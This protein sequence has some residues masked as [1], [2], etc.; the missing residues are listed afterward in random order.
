M[1]KSLPLVKIQNTGGAQTNVPFT[2]GQVFAP[3]DLAPTDGLMGGTLALQVDVKAAH[4]DGS[5]RHAVIS[6]VLPKLAAGETVALQLAK[7]VPAKTG[8]VSPDVFSNLADLDAK[9]QLVVGADTYTAS[10][11]G[12]RFSDLKLWLSGST[13][14]EG[15]FRVPLK[16]AAGI[17]HP[18]LQVQ[19]GVRYY[20]GA[21]VAR[22]EVIVENSKTWKQGSNFTYDV[23]V[24]VAG[25][26]V[27]SKKAQPH[28]HHARW[29][30]VAW[31][32]G[33]PGVLV[34][35][36]T[37]Y[38]IAAKAVPNYDQTIVPAEST[39]ASLGAQVT[40]ANTG[41]MTIG[42]VMADMGSTGGRPDIGPLPQWSVYYLLSRDRRAYD[43]M[44]AAAEGSASWS[45]H[46]RDENT[47]YPLRTD[48]DATKNVSMHFNMRDQGPLPVPRIDPADKTGGGTPYANDTAHEPSLVYLPYLITG[49]YY[50]LEELQFWAATN[51]LATAAGG[52][53][54][55]KG[56]VRWQQ[57]R[58]QAWSMRTLGHVAYITPD[59]DPLKAYFTQ[60]LDNNLEFYYQTYVMGNPNKLGVYDGSGDS[61]FRI[62]KAVAPWQDD[63]FTWA[64]AH[65]CEL[66]FENAKPIR[67]WK[68][69]FVLG[70]MTDPGFCWIMAASYFLWHRQDPNSPVFD[71]FA[72][73]YQRTFGE[74]MRSDNDAPVSRDIGQKF[75]ALPCASQA[76]ADLL[77]SINKTTPD[78]IWE[79]L[80]MAGYADS[81]DGYSAIMQICLAA[82]VDSGS[83]EAITAWQT[84]MTRKNKPDYSRGPQF[85]IVPR[86]AVAAAAPVITTPINTPAPAVAVL[87][88]SDAPTEPGNWTKVGAENTHVK[89]AAG[90][91]VRYGTGDKWVY[92]KAL[93]GEF[94]ATNTAFGKDPA[95]NVVKQVEAFAPTPKT[96][97]VVSVTRYAV[98]EVIGGAEGDTVAE[99]KTQSAAEKVAD[100]LGKNK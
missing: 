40:A 58:G 34:H 89:V 76:Q 51:P 15:R 88:P 54:N 68:L 67:D 14:M 32:D 66:G 44:M 61:A 42:P 8:T 65:L 48:S 50:L 43:L 99:M 49:D 21:K 73:V 87:L 20:P 33:E 77:T 74:D 72:Q 45:V 75:L 12:A 79:R 13:A 63:Y 38:L 24:N 25:R 62:E 53:G 47:G 55:G 37:A 84:F 39:L 36:D 22:V 59:A 86:I 81:S 23:D 92:A 30:Q 64:F 17:E 95:Y 97:K 100:L 7:V 70:R 78:F 90:T 52:H 69:K 4:Q 91:Q 19:F 60:Q 46:Y 41:P 10:V 6:G 31:T 96:Y 56:L 27:Y 94:D 98:V 85:A 9:V 29:R 3:G 5:V 35:P 93:T 71:T 28:Y 26:S 18:L 11:K 1:A 80:R 2:F 57:V 83:K 82:A 16:N